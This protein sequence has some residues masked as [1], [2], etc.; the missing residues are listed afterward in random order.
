MVNELQIPGYRIEE[1]I[2]KGGM[3]VV[4][5]AIQIALDRIVA[6]KILPAHLAEDHEFVTS[7]SQEAKTVAKLNH[8]NIV[9]VYDF[10]NHQ[11]TYYLVMQFVEGRTLREM[12]LSHKPPIEQIASILTQVGAAL[13]YAH[14]KEVVHRDVKPSNIMLC[15]DGKAM[16][17][18]FGVACGSHAGDMSGVWTAVGTP[19]YMSP[20]QCKGKKASPRSDQYAMGVTVYEMLAGRVPFKGDNASVMQQHLTS[21]PQPLRGV[22]PEVTLR[23][24]A[25]VMR[26]MAKLPD[27]RFESVSAFAREFE[28]GYYEPSASAQAN[29]AVRSPLSTPAPSPGAPVCLVGTPPSDMPLPA[30]KPASTY[31]TMYAIKGGGARRTS[32]WIWVLILTVLGAIGA[33]GYFLYPKLI[34]PAEPVKSEAPTAAEIAAKRARM[35]RRRSSRS[36]N[37]ASARTG[38]AAT[39][40]AGDIRKKQ[41]DAGPPA[42]DA[43]STPGTSAPDSA[44]DEKP[45]AGQHKDETAE[46]PNTSDQ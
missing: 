21:P 45:D 29:V 36:G 32:P 8:P 10:G 33:A 3:G 15:P 12:L 20:E 7:F 5:K 41:I 17:M 40:A 44:S 6:I 18:D 26:A 13:D 35:Q 11:G 16:I 37:G 4:Y 28:A 31:S 30:Q 2:G 34:Q 43:G 27:V 9:P 24:E 22:R 23:L 38:T 46:K 19:N 14:S 39:S 42:A 25:S 1:P